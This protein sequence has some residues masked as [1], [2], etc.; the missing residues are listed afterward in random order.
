MNVRKNDI[1][2]IRT[3]ADKGKTGK[4]LF[5]N[6]KKSK[7]VVEGINMRKKHQRPTQRSQK[8]GIISIEGTV[9]ISNVALYNSSVNKPE[10]IKMTV[11][12]EGKNARRVRVFKISGEEV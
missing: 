5:I 1:V 3:G 8:G 4:V 9:H 6:R 7:L 2:Y 12:G 10:K 11:V